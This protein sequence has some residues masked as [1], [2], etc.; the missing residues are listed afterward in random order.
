MEL[1]L[2]TV[3]IRNYGQFEELDLTL[4]A[5]RHAAFGRLRLTLVVGQNG[6]GKTTFFR[7]LTDLFS[8]VPDV[9]LEECSA[10]YRI[11]RPR[12][13]S[14]ARKP[15]V[16]VPSRIIVSTYSPVDGFGS[17]FDRA[18]RVVPL[19]YLGLDVERAFKE[20][21]NPSRVFL[22]EVASTML[23]ES[24]ERRKQV[25]R[26]LSTIGFSARI[27]LLIDA[28]RE[29]L[30]MRLNRIDR[31]LVRNPESFLAAA[32]RWMSFLG[33]VVAKKKPVRGRVMLDTSQLDW[34]PTGVE[35]F[36]SDLITLAGALRSVAYFPITALVFQRGEQWIPLEDFSSG[37]RAL[38]FRFLGLIREIKDDALVLVDEPEIHLHPEWVQRFVGLLVS[39]FRDVNAHVLIASHSPLIASDVPADCILGLRKE[40]VKIVPYTVQDRSLGTSPSIILREVFGLADDKGDFTR[41]VIGRIEAY[42]KAGKKRE[43]LALYDLLGDSDEKYDLFRNLRGLSERS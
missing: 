4:P 19:K 30:R 6:T 35:G 38:F 16:E 26:L 5:E 34:Y 29:R 13:I 42:I 1:Q 21:R 7:F 40:G 43:A 10:T 39:L 23:G 22:G 20:F 14:G 33:Y 36:A 8:K 12:L 28:S 18:D 31:G 41:E 17:V 32:E 24:V 3:T 9:E 37:E 25:E 11:R 15:P 27:R 2:Q